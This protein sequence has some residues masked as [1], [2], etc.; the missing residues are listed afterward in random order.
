M[1][2][3]IMRKNKYGVGGWTRISIISITGAVFVLLF[4]TY[5]IKMCTQAYY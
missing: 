4:K 3:N 2:V 1:D 5:F